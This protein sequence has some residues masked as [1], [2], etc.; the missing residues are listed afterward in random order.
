[1]SAQHSP[2]EDASEVLKID[3]PYGHDGRLQVE[4]LQKRTLS[5]FVPKRDLGDLATALRQ[6]FSSPIDFPELKQACVPGDR[7]VLVLHPD[8]PRADAVIAMLW[9]QLSNAGIAADDVLILQPTT[10][11]AH[12][13]NDPRGLLP[14]DVR[15]RMVVKQ[16]DPTDSTAC[17]YLSSTL[18][19]ERIYLAKEI[20][21]AD[22]VIPIGPASF[23]PVLG[24]RGESS[25]VYPAC[26]NTE[27]IQRFLGQGHDEL[28]PGDV[29]PLRTQIEEVGWLL[30]MQYAVS[31]IPGRGLGV[32]AIYSG[33]TEGVSRA[34]QAELRATCLVEV[35]ERAELV[36]IA[37]EADAGG[38]GWEQVTTAIDMARKVVDRNGRIV[39]LTQLDAQPGPGLKSL[40]NVRTPAE[41][42][43]LLRKQPPPDYLSAMQLARAV[44]W[45]NVYLLS[46]LPA[47]QVE[48]MFMIPLAAPDEVLKLLTGDDTVIVIES[49]QKV[50][51]H[52]K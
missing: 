45:A 5:H 41:A 50:F 27:A 40:G 24:Y 11:Q 48:E 44:D 52:C 37:I 46:Q 31:L 23:D 33:L 18:D 13:W 8:T 21:D 7:V 42:I 32:Q 15:E 47:E 16:H 20:V 3:I 6:S 9:K 30:G 19:G 39:V 25:F 26:S 4:L 12:A 17:A 14:P 49:G 38:H 1:M 43:Q 10:W 51:A 2:H 36:L 28:S 35:E 34:A 29:R 22:L